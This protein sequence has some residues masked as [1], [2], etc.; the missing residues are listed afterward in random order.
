MQTA[1]ALVY[2]VDAMPRRRQRRRNEKQRRHASPTGDA[3]TGHD[4]RPAGYVTRL[5]YTRRQAAEA[6]GVSLATLDRRVVPTI[7]TVKTEWGARL[8]PIDELE[9]Y[10]AERKQS[11]RRARRPPGRPGRKS[12]LEPEL[13]AR[14]RSDYAKGRTLGEIARQLNTDGVRTSQGGRHWWPSTVRAVLVR[15]SPVTSA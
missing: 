14:I 13:V 12:G 7:E 11:A 10:L 9:G 6:L 1:S 2:G 15:S 3:P 5:A 8:I 4:L